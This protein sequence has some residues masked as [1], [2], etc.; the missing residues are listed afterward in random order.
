MGK[1]VY[2]EGAV[3]RCSLSQDGSEDARKVLMAR[4]IKTYVCWGVKYGG[5]RREATK[6]RIEDGP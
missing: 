2:R 4:K 3:Q 1:I 5:K 6:L